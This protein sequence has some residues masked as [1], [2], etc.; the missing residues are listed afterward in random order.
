VAAALA[1][2]GDAE[3]SATLLGAAT[4]AAE[5]AG[6]VLEPLERT[7][8]DDTGRA[9]E[10]ALGEEVAAALSEA[11]RRLTLADAVGRALGDFHPR[12]PA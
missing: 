9:L 8:H 12:V 7:I 5:A 2:L 6:I 3:Q 1:V 10:S 11:G 4:A